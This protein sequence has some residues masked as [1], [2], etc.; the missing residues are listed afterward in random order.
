MSTPTPEGSI[1][2]TPPAPDRVLGD[3][4]GEDN[5][6]LQPPTALADL[7]SLAKSPRDSFTPSA[8]PLVP[9]T[10]KSLEENPIEVQ[11]ARR[12]GSL[13]RRPVFW[14]LAAAAIVAVVL[15]V[16]L[17]VYFMVIRPKNNTGGGGN[18]GGNN[19][20]TPE[21][22]SELTTG[23]DGST[24]TMEN[25]TQFTYHNPF[26]GFCAH[27]P[28]ILECKGA[29]LIAQLQGSGIRKIRSMTMLSRTRG[30]RL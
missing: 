5:A 20:G 15:S 9:E 6:P 25:G 27:I 2:S 1:P 13:F 3:A 17:P 29:D 4:P 19:S 14:F 23:G 28:F 7:T 8:A 12:R 30:R 26:G 21:P 16:I 11:P 10:E 18:S 24:V 22:L